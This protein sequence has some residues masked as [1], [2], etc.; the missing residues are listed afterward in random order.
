MSRFAC[1]QRT[2]FVVAKSAP[3]RNGPR[4]FLASLPC[5]SSPNRTR[6]A[7]LQLGTQ[8][9]HKQ[10]RFTILGLYPSLR[11]IRAAHDGSALRCCHAS[12]RF[13]LSGTGP[14][15]RIRPCRIRDKARRFRPARF[16]ETGD[17]RSYIHNHERLSPIRRPPA[18]NTGSCYAQNM[19]HHSWLNCKF[20]CWR[21]SILSAIFSLKVFL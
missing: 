6:F 7:G 19:I 3:S 2:A 17:L 12:F 11:S 21:L 18:M 20:F 16:T 1:S 8:S 9:G 14:R 10:N 5:F 13:A 15:P 4:P